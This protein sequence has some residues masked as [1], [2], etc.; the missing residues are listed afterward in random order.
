MILY[1]TATDHINKHP[2]GVMLPPHALDV[3]VETGRRRPPVTALTMIS[4]T[5]V[6]RTRHTIATTP[7]PIYEPFDERLSQRARVTIAH[8]VTL[9]MSETPFTILDDYDVLTILH[10]IDAYVAETYPLRSEPAV[11]AYFER[12]L[13][14][15]SRIYALFRRVL[16]H[17]PQ[18]KT[19]YTEEQGLLGVLR[20]LYRS[21]GMS[22]GL[23]QTLLDDLEICPTVRDH[24]E[25]F[26]KLRPAAAS[27][28]LGD[29]RLRYNV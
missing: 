21:F 13:K 29:G 14:L 19:A 24:P 16:N 11:T 10:Q 6:Q 23:P 8:M 22:G 9:V 28:V 12:I 15:R 17:R 3:P 25:D 4:G 27:P 18:W 5:L 26:S 7:G 20:D 2:Y 1:P